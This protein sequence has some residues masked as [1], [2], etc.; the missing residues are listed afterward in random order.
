MKQNNIR[1]ILEKHP[2]IPVVTFNELSEV[3]PQLEKL[4]SQG[5]SCIEITL[6]TPISFDA[7]A[8]AKRA[9]G[10]RIDIGVG[11]L[12]TNEQI[13]KAAE[14]NVDF[15]VSPGISKSLA[16]TF[17]SC[18]IPFIPGVATPSEIITGLELGWDTFKFFPAHLFGGL[19]ALKTYGQVFP[20]VKFC[21]TGGIKA[22]TYE[23]YLKLSNVISVG[24]SWLQ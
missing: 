14:L 4:E 6:R 12:V 22:E 1:A 19:D 17:E 9:F 23:H 3:V 18:G 15:M 10:K 16:P 21:P 24:G 2:I 7:I 20:Q 11:T 8:E 13:E 5:V